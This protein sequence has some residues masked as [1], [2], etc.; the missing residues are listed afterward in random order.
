MK[1]IT[2]PSYE[3][4]QFLNQH[5]IQIIL[6]HPKSNDSIKSYSP[7]DKLALV[8]GSEDKGLSKNWLDTDNIRLN[9]NSSGEVDSINASTAAAI[10][11]W[12]LS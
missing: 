8:I 2:A 9:I 12:E 7:S 3:I 4:V 5:N 10:A 1:V 11:M 6:L